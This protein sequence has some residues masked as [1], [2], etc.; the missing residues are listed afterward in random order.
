MAKPR[1]GRSQE[2]V[3][4]A[5]GILVRSARWIEKDEIQ[6]KAG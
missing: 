2:A 6:P 5:V 3:A 1:A 4:A